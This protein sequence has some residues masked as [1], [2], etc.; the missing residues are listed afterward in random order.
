MSSKDN[1]W[2]GD[3]Q[4]FCPHDVRLPAQHRLREVNVGWLVER[5][6]KRIETLS[7]K[8]IYKNTFL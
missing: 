1:V 7:F 4:G 2:M 5:P 6:A 8:T 3:H